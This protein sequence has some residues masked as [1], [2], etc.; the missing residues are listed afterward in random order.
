MIVID[1]SAV[2]DVL[3]GD[4]DDAT[5]RAL[6]LTEEALHAPHLLDVE[7]LHAVRGLLLRGGIDQQRADLAVADLAQLEITRYPHTALRSRVW[8]L[9]DNLSAYDATY[10]AL[11]EVLDMPLLTADKR[12][13]TA[14]GV[15]AQITVL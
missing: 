15:T 9:R 2:V 10:V 12:L 7:V 11:A 14:P 13:A 6:R 1:A 8:Q 5:V 3:L 4:S